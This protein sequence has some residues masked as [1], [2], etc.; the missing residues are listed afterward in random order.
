MPL[1]E[2]V[3]PPAVGKSALAEALFRRGV[4]DARREFHVSRRPAFAPLAAAARRAGPRWRV[5]ADR[6]LLPPGPEQVEAALAKASLSWAPFL[7]LILEGPGSTGSLAPEARVIALLERSWL[8]DAVQRQAL[9]AALP[10][11]REILVLDEG[12]T[13]PYKALAVSGADDAVLDRYAALVPLPDVLVVV[14]AHP[15][16][17]AKRLRERHRTSPARARAA[18]IG[19]SDAAIDAE[20]ARVRH[21]VEV[22]ALTAVSRSCRVIRLAVEDDGPGVLANRLLDRFAAE[23][24]GVSS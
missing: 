24:L 8:L 13:H 12:L 4:C 19:A 22:V 15:D 21:A 23:G 1:V 9:L 3:G 18:V 2:L 6:L 5:I 17:I 11:S 14:D 7:A 10:A 16:L 20:V